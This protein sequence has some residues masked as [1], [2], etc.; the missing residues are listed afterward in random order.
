MP[1]SA[2]LVLPCMNKV[3]VVLENLGITDFFSKLDGSQGSIHIAVVFVPHV[4]VA[5]RVVTLYA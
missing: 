2:M 5:M 3:C 4:A 1:L